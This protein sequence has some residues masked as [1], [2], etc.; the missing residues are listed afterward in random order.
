M[1][2]PTAAHQ[3]AREQDTALSEL[4]RPTKVKGIDVQFVP[5]QC[6][7]TA[8]AGNDSVSL[9]LRVPTT[10]H[11][12]A[13][14]HEMPPGEASEAKARMGVFHDDPFHAIAMP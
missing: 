13:L 2:E 6:S 4:V 14:V 12:V 3:F 9:G 10:R 11:D 1:K 5:F 8:R 7:T